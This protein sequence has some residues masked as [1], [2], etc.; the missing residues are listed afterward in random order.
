M[1]RKRVWLIYLLLFIF[2]ACKEETKTDPNEDTRDK[3]SINISADESFK[4]VLE[5]Q[6]Q[7]YESDHPN[8]KLSVH[9]KPEADCIRDLTSDST[10]MIIV[11][12]YISEDEIA[13]L[14]DSLKTATTQM[15]MAHDAVAII[16]HPDEEIQRFTMS[17][18]KAILQGK[19][20]K[21]LI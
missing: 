11:A 5:A 10:R 21:N 14:Q 7:V 8:A 4:P 16:L 17:D 9:Y 12:K 3:G 6:V 13:F 15:M 19:F 18:L 1:L 20:R 2:P